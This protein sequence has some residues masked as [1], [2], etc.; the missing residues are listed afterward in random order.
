MSELETKIFYIFIILSA[1]LLG[2]ISQI[3]LKKNTYA[4]KKYTY[5]ILL[6]S[7]IILNLPMAFRY[8]T[9]ADYGQYVSLFEKARY[10][11][12]FS[13]EISNVE[14]GYLW[15]NYIC[16]KL[17]NN[18]Q[19]IF[20]IIATLTNFLFF[21]GLFYYRKKI[22]FGIAIFTYGFTIYFFGFI[23][24]R[25]MLASAIIFY[26]LRFIAEGKNKKFYFFIVIASMFHYS[27]IVFILIAVILKS[28]RKTSIKKLVFYEII[29]I[30]I[31]PSLIN[32]IAKIFYSTISRYSNYSVVIGNAE[33]GISPY[34]IMN[35][36][37]LGV[38][39]IRYKK[40]K[41]INKD[42]DIYFT[43]YNISCILLLFLGSLPLI[44]RFIYPLWTSLFILFPTL[45]KSF[46]LIKN[47]RIR[48]I[49]KSI[50]ILLIFIYGLMLINFY[51][52]NENYYLIPYRSIFS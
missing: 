26:A 25:G 32:I 38:F 52:T 19:S 8:Y 11:D 36:I 22:N 48:F 39:L 15:I 40:M 13:R 3:S 5:I 37:P 4:N 21:K 34:I 17:F 44:S 12:N 7:F 9:G 51:I 10:S 14:V 28:V 46:N 29:F 47:N 2:Y 41:E 1:S 43:L 24:I 30:P 23:I 35:L 42:I 49:I 33:M 16:S 45:I 18:Y 20:I 50:T 6:L 27:S 31:L